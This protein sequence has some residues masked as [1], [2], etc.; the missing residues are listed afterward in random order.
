MESFKKHYHKNAIILVYK[1]LKK[2]LNFSYVSKSI[3]S[4]NPIYFNCYLSLNYSLPVMIGHQVNTSLSLKRRIKVFLHFRSEVFHQIIKSFV[5]KKSLSKFLKF[6]W[7]MSFLKS[8]SLS[9][10]KKKSLYDF[11]VP[12][13]PVFHQVI[14][15]FV[16][17][18]RWISKISWNQVFF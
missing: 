14:K 7:N 3:H 15:S 13:K 4:N 5:E 18:K 1:Y 8:S 17:E 9:V 12:F 10:K 2:F 16:E 6:S 11:Q